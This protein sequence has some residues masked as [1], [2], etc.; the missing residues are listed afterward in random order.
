MSG[1]EDVAEA[2]AGRIETALDAAAAALGEHLPGPVTVDA[3]PGRRR[4][5]MADEAAARE[6]GAGG[7]PAEPFVTRKVRDS[8]DDFA[9]AM[10]EA[11]RHD[12]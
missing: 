10:T 2:L 8:R 1:F 12:P 5:A 11:L 7:R 3:G 6:F 9:A 4:V